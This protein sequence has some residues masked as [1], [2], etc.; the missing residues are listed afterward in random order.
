MKVLVTG[1]SGL[2]GSALV[3]ALRGAGHS[4]VRL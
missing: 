1:S 4:V 3:P 2:I